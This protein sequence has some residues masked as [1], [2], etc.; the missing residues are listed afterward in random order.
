MNASQLQSLDRTMYLL[1]HTRLRLRWLDPV[2]VAV[3]HAGTKG[4]VWLGIC[5]VVFISGASH[6]Q[7]AA[8]LAV[9]VLLVA[10][11]VSNLVF[12]PAIHRQRPFARTATLVRP[13]IRL[14]ADH[15]WP[16]AHA[17]SSF[18]AALVLAWSFPVA[19]VPL[20]LLAALISYSRIYVGV[21]Y[22]FDVLAGTLIGVCL[23]M[24]GIGLRAL[25]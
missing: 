12:K 19:A 8:L 24:G 16:S 11:G 3:T 20:V 23:G 22:P 5:V 1:I 17:A 15:S 13:L 25:V 7:Q 2:M 4:A 18:A 9:G 14:P 21:H 10:Q 6:S